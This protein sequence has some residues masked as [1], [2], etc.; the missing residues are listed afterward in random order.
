MSLILTHELAHVFKLDD[1][2]DD[3]EHNPGKL[4]SGYYPDPFC[5][6]QRYSRID[7]TKVDFYRNVLD[8]KISVFCND[9]ASLILNNMTFV[10]DSLD[11]Q[12]IY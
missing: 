8:G 7:E 1:Q 2:Y 3:D 6:M 4:D 9:C 10:P 12:D 5:A 11:Y